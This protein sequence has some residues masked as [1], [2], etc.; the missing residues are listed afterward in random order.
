MSGMTGYDQA[1]SYSTSQYS[2]VPNLPSATGG[3][4]LNG[5]AGGGSTGDPNGS[6]GDPRH[7]HQWHH[8]GYHQPTHGMQMPQSSPTSQ[9]YPSYYDRNGYYIHQQQSLDSQQSWHEPVV[10]GSG[11]SITGGT[12]TPRPESPSSMLTGSVSYTHLTLPTN[13]EV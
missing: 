1:A 13:R 5:Q 10:P 4:G 12:T 9:R 6:L 3:T 11:V 8:G 7:L 2:Y